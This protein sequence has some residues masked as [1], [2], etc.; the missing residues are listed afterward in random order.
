MKWICSVCGYVHEGDQPPAQCPQCKVPAEKFVQAKE[1][2]TE[3]ADQHVVGVAKGVD[4]A[5]IEDL[6][7]NFTGECPSSVEVIGN[8]RRFLKVIA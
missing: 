7:A 8:F 6:R 4:P 1:G 5:I 3:W 2:K